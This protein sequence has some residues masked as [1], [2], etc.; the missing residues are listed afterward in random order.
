MVK[1]QWVV[2]CSLH[3]QMYESSDTCGM[4]IGCRYNGRCN[5][6]I[7][8]GCILLPAALGDMTC[9]RGGGCSNIAFV[10]GCWALW[11]A[12]E[13]GACRYSGRCR[14]PIACEGGHLWHWRHSPVPICASATGG[15]CW[16]CLCVECENYVYPHLKWTKGEIVHGCSSHQFFVWWVHVTGIRSEGKLWLSRRVCAPSSGP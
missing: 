15:Q 3:R 13:P 1:I 12:V 8:H 5:A 7:V 14:S 16:G 11:A 4:I 9:Y 2:R 6:L 10:H